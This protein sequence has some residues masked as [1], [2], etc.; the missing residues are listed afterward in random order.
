MKAEYN[1]YIYEKN[2]SFSIGASLFLNNGIYDFHLADG[3]TCRKSHRLKPGI[4]YAMF[5]PISPQFYSNKLR[6]VRASL[7]ITADRF[8][9]KSRSV[10]WAQT[11]IFSFSLWFY[12]VGGYQT[13]L[14][15]SADFRTQMFSFVTCLLATRRTFLHE[16]VVIRKTL[17]SGSVW[18]S[19]T[20]C[21]MPSC[22]L[23]PF[24]KSCSVFQPLD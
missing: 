11:L 18:S 7:Q 9:R 19:V 2:I 8:H 6:K 16:F 21:M 17:K 20:W 10:W 4:H 22:P 5:A 13:C 15:F 14:I 3:K 23:S 24:I 12:P 1:F